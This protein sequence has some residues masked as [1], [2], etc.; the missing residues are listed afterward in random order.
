MEWLEDKTWVEHYS[1]IAVHGALILALLGRPGEAERWA[2]AAERAAS[3]GALPDGDTTEGVLAYLRALLCRDGIAEM[4]RDAQTA[5]E[6]L[7]P[8]SPYRAT[9]LHTEGIS[10]LLE[11]DPDRAE[12]ILAHALDVAIAAGAVPL[13][14]LILAERGIAASHRADW[15]AAQAFAEQALTNST[16][17]S[18]RRLLDQRPGVRLGGP[19]RRPPRRRG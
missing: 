19:H 4:R 9:M 5:W 15:S 3:P 10:Y 12:P 16:R 2:A 17:R 7:S 8:T 11:S 1:A 13:V 14:A 6:Q 18:L